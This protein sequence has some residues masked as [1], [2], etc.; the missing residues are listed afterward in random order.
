M[1]LYQYICITFTLLFCSTILAQENRRTNA[2]NESSYKKHV[3]LGWANHSIWDDGLAEVATYEANQRIYGKNRTY[4]CIYITVKEVF[5]EAYNVKT[6]DYSRT[7]L[8]DVIKVNRFERIET[9]QYPY[10]YTSNLFFKRNDA[11]KLHKMTVSSQEW[12]GST[13]KTF[14]PLQ[15]NT[16]YRIQYHSY[17]DGE[18]EG[19][20]I[21]EGDFLFEDQ[22][23]FTLRM[24][25]LSQGLQFNARFMATQVNA[26]VGPIYAD[27]AIFRVGSTSYT[28]NET[29]IEAWKVNVQLD[30]ERANIYIIEKA[31]PN[32][33]LAINTWDQR[34][35]KL[36]EIKRYAYWQ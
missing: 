10:H 12:C 6:D 21:Q 31:H 27:L 23:P 4:D 32:R 16:G 7:D 29:E 20:K 25:Q 35:L 15:N 30:L 2:I 33:L 17:W 11:L 5:N 19:E 8:F 28:L 34:N 36:K 24:M 1:P 18:G 14:A 3:N 26:K 22:L 13:F 9:E